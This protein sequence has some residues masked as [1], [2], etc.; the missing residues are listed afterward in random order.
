[1]AITAPIP[2]IDLA[3]RTELDAL[4][5]EFPSASIVGSTHTNAYALLDGRRLS[6]V[7][8]RPDATTRSGGTWIT[9]SGQEF[10]SLTFAVAVALGRPNETMR[11]VGSRP[12]AEQIPEVAAYF[13]R[14]RSACEAETAL[15]IVPKD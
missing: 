4:A 2:P 10:E 1:M 8:R 5:S 13:E 6:L 9:P 11:R 14:L 12:I 15:V 7:V 3:F